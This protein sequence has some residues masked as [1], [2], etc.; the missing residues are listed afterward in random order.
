VSASA[1]KVHVGSTRAAHGALQPPNLAPDAA[2]A[3]SVTDSPTAKRASHVV[4]QSMPDWPEKLVDLSRS[5]ITT[6]VTVQKDGEFDDRYFVRIEASRGSSVVLTVG[7][8]KLDELVESLREIIADHD[9][10]QT[11]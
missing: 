10:R 8:E 2:V 1:S 6:V 7:G 3:V 4:P 9:V 5:F 11:A